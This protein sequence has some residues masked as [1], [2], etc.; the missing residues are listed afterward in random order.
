MPTTA[1]VLE[2][3]QLAYAYPGQAPLFTAATLVLGPGVHLLYGDTGSGKST[4]LRLIAG[5]LRA[6]TGSLR[7]GDQSL[8]SAPDAYRRRVFFCEPD[9]TAFDQHTVRDCTL[10]L[11]AGDPDFDTAAWH[12]LTEA[13]A[14]VPHL[15]KPLYMLSTGSKRKVWLAAALASGRPLA[16]LDD[17]TAGLDAGSVRALFRALTQ[18]AH[19]SGRT[20]LVASS[21]AL[22]QVPWTST[23]TLPLG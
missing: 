14:L 2:V 1:P 11:Q 15:D 16:L 5:T 8:H 3:Q 18:H 7:V 9:N 10:A 6:N 17:P 21:E 23:I 12:Q 22:P 4:L 20:V 13:L 19:A